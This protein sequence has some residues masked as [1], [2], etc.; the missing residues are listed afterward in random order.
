MSRQEHLKVEAENAKMLDELKKFHQ[1][2]WDFDACVSKECQRLKSTKN[3]GAKG[4][5][6]LGN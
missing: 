6:H 2:C 4:S 5:L 3:L 1:K